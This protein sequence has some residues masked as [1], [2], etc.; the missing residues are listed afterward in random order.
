MGH[1]LFH[2]VRMYSYHF[3]SLGGLTWR[4]RMALDLHQKE[5][6]SYTCIRMRGPHKIR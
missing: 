1:S 2:L 3:L 6:T 5:G 4:Y